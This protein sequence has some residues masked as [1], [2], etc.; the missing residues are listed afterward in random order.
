VSVE[1]PK[2]IA[3]CSTA[4]LDGDTLYLVDD[5]RALSK[6]PAAIVHN[7][8]VGD[9]KSF[10]R[11][12]LV[13]DIE[14]G[15]LYIAHDHRYT[16][17]KIELYRITAQA[18]LPISKDD[19][20]ATTVEKR[21]FGR[22]EFAFNDTLSYNP[23]SI[24]M[25]EGDKG[26]PL[27]F[28]NKK[29]HS[30]EPSAGLCWWDGSSKKGYNVGSIEEEDNNRAPIISKFS[31]LYPL[32]IVP[33]SLSSGI[34]N[35]PNKLNHDKYSFFVKQLVHIAGSQKKMLQIL[36]EERTL[37]YDSGKYKR[38]FNIFFDD[39]NGVLKYSPGSGSKL[40]ISKADNSTHKYDKYSI[41][42][43]VDEDPATVGKPFLDTERVFVMV[44]TKTGPVKTAKLYYTPTVAVSQPPS[45]ALPQELD[46]IS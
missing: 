8:K 26:R 30:S 44:D 42:V 11:G 37:F 40:I 36:P 28:I 19:E 24:H 4:S 22:R 13:F 27:H 21:S 38:V 2:I 14:T 16:N 6:I 25:L 41:S 39:I 9:D 31:Q 46:D 43:H 12:D 35:T 33:V 17:N 23:I 10:H 1:K 45:S 32:D 29:T 20:T 5:T 7:V 3:K 34:F 18:R 15:I